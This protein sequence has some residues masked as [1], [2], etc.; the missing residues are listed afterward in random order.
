MRMVKIFVN[1]FGTIGKRVAFAIK[2]QDDMELVGVAKRRPDFKA[3]IANKLGIPLYVVSEE[4][5][6]DFEELGIKV[7][8]VLE[9][10]IE[11]ADIIVD[12]APKGVGS[13]NKSLYDRNGKKAVFQ[14]G[15][16]PE[17]ADISFVAQ[18]NYE[19]ALGKR[20][21]RV[22]SCN[23]TGMARVLHELRKISN[24]RKVRGILVRRAA[25]PWE[26]KKG[27]IDA[28]VPTLKIPS[29]HASDV[30]TV[31]G[32]LDIMTLA[33]VVPTTRMHLHVLNVEF[34]SSVTVGDI[35]DTLIDAP[36]ILVVPVRLGLD[37][38]AT[39][40]EFARDMGRSRNDLYEVMVFDD[41]IKVHGNELWLKYAVHQEAIVV[42]E[43]IDAIR[44]AMR[45]FDDP[46]KSIEKTDSSLGIL[47]KL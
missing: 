41:S 22:V 37:S 29:H 14:G 36:R 13:K 42:P 34:E 28:I 33:V 23:T 30:K 17:V 46:M 18:A 12:A 26:I 43:N 7:C 16:P 21:I 35:V 20:Y 27:P 11:K 24:I 45:M 40:V 31:L 9:E 4:N 44:A 5:I 15:E 6:G 10:G 3:Y 2:K 19:K 1:G 8:G 38:T 39:L 25:D 32:E 47:R